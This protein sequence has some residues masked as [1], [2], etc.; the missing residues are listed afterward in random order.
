MKYVK[1][2]LSNWTNPS[3]RSSRAEYWSTYLVIFLLA[4]IS[5]FVSE[6]LYSLIVIAD[7]FIGIGL[8]IRRMHDVGVSGWFLIVPFLNIVYALSKSEEKENKWGPIPNESR[9]NMAKSITDVVEEVPKN[10]KSETIFND[11]TDITSDDEIEELER[12]LSELQEL[13]KQKDTNQNLEEKRK[14]EILEEI[15]KLNKELNE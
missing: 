12:R 3:G 10:N 15:E 4:F 9:S 6:T 5:L 1:Q 7:L 14:K 13:K 8:G 11:K 2:G